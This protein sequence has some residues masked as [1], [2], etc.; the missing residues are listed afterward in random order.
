M[1]FRSW[2]GT[3]HLASSTNQ[4]RSLQTEQPDIDLFW[5]RYLGSDDSVL[6]LSPSK[7][8]IVLEKKYREGIAKFYNYAEYR[9]LDF[10]Q[11]EPYGLAAARLI[12][13]VEVV[14]LSDNG[15]IRQLHLFPAH[16]SPTGVQIDYR[17]P[18]VFTKTS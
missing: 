8:I 14:D 9:V 17:P 1:L 6:V 13:V 10:L 5:G 7:S 3:Y 18:Y 16:I 2:S 15:A 4:S 11:I 12:F